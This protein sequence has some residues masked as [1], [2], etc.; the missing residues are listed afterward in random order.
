MPA[1]I[2]KKGRTRNTYAHKVEEG[3]M[4]DGM[5]QVT[6]TTGSVKLLLFGG[7]VLFDVIIDPLHYC[8]GSLFLSRLRSP[9]KSCTDKTEKDKH[10]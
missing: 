6:P 1:H 3:E 10:F 8:G 9:P 2:K 7:H 4:W 5:D